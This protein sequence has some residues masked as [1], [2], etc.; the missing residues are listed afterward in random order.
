M[1]NASGSRHSMGFVLETVVGTTPDTPAF[2]A[3]RHNTTN[4][5]LSKTV[6][7]SAELRSDRQTTDGRHG[8]YSVG[9]DIAVE[10]SYGSFDTII[11]ALFGGTW[12][13][14][15]L[16]G[17]V[18]RRSYTIE[19]RF[20]DINQ[21]L[22]YRGCEFDKMSL[23]VKPNAMATATFGI[24]GRTADPASGSAIAGSTYPAATTTSPMDSFTGV[25]EENG[26]PI[27]VVTEISLNI[28][29]GIA[30]MYVVGQK[31]AAD[32]SIGRFKVSGQ[33]TAFFDSVVML[34]KFINE[35]ESDLSFQTVGTG[36]T[37]EWFLPRIKY[38][39]GQPDVGGEGT[40]SLAMPFTAY[41][42]ETEASSIVL[43]R[44]PA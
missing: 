2:S 26:S 32:M 23:S 6:I 10:L 31:G 7:E 40:I 38:N 14:N 4:L 21:Y 25:I 22:R 34:N 42:D 16:K 11:E 20:Q 13:A 39:G 29:N 44:T 8:N 5:A 24:V 1:P 12:T 19:R 3:I 41:Y 33:I 36:G 35:T 18:L 27:A 17:G 9:G 37:Y 30:P 28:E 15:V 43:T